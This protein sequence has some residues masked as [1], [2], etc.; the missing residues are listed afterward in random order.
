[1]TLSDFPF[2]KRLP[3]PLKYLCGLWVLLLL[4]SPVYSKAQSENHAVTLYSGLKKNILHSKKSKSVGIVSDIY[5]D[6][7][8]NLD[9]K[10]TMQVLDS[11]Q[12]LAQQLHD[13]ALV[14]C[15]YQ[16][17]A[18]YYAIHR[19]YNRL[20]IDYYEK[21]IN[22]AIAHHLQAETGI[23]LHKKG[24]FYF[25][26]NHYT[27]AYLDF[28]KA[29]DRF[30]ETGF[31]HIGHISR[32]MAEQARFYYLLKD[33]GKA[34]TLLQEALLYPIKD[35]RVHTS[36]TTTTGLVYR[37]YHQYAKALYYFNQSLNIA[38]AHKDSSMIGIAMGDIGSIYVIQGQY[39]AA[40]PYLAK[41]YVYCQKFGETGGSV[42]ALLRLSDIN[43]RKN[44]FKQAAIR[45]DS[46]V[47]LIP[48]SKNDTL[49][50]YLELYKQRSYLYEKTGNLKAAL[51]YNK[52]YNKV[53]DVLAERNSK[54]AVA[55]AQLE[56]E[57][58]KYYSELKKIKARDEAEQFKRYA[59]IAVIFLLI[60]IFILVFKRHRLKAKKDKEVLLTKKQQVDEKLESAAASLQLYTES[61]KQSN[62]LIEKFKEEIDQLKAQATDSA[63][64]RE[65]EE[66]VQAHIMTD[67]T[68]N[69]F[70]KLFS[71][72]HTGF[73]VKLRRKYPNLTDTD[74]RLLALIKLDLNN[75]EMANMLGITIEGIK[76]AKQR[77][78]KKMQLSSG[79]FIEQA[80]ENL[81]SV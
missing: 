45:M 19:G 20:S 73:F 60:I 76:K 35:Q 23:Y 65:I 3:T 67:E 72:V 5:R 9:E 25:K 74:M 77:L 17:R 6:S 75:K 57:T 37:S 81:E 43:L 51:L 49:T 4:L 26:F 69:E 36:L 42:T 62:S 66:L 61:L 50:Y 48:G 27:E 10:T 56:W 32:Y 58:E 68:W 71:K 1:M 28:L 34:L 14:C 7:C 40:I 46:A 30:K 59:L 80:L 39:Q 15:L 44:E 33:Y 29:Y 31:E 63:G 24:M 2:K 64:V 21:S 8:R 38:R 52:K 22:Y 70:K 18:D 41:A 12:L 78:R 54:V 79:L 55:S 53:S 11:V 13:G 16:L 47:Y